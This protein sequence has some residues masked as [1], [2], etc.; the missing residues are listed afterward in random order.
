MLFNEPTPT[1]YDLKFRVL[2]IPVRVHPL[3]WL[4]AVLM[5]MRGNPQ[6]AEILLWVGAVFVSILVHEMGHALAARACGWQPWI[7]LHGFGGLAS[8][9]P[10]YRSPMN[11]VLITLAGP[12][13]G[14]LFAATI[15]AFI[16]A[17]GHRVEF[18]WHGGLF[19]FAY[20][21]FNAHRLNMLIDDLLFINIFWGLI[22]LLPILPLDGGQIAQEV[23]QLMSPGDGLRQAFWL[24]ILVAI[25]AGILAWTRLHDQYLTFFCAYFAYSNYMSLQAF[26]GRGGG[27][28]R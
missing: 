5:G 26:Y 7:T 21:G 12:V 11:Q 4:I 22:N 28:F 9:R 18:G 24:S 8:Y 13:A 10:T 16:Q 23:L 17:S 3:F 20:E 14:F 15:V 19:P 27:G 25:G 2:G 6:P 1:A